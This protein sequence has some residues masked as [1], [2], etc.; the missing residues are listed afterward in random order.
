[1]RR[2]GGCNPKFGKL[3]VKRVAPQCRSPYIRRSM[4]LTETDNIP[5][6]PPGTRIDYLENGLA[7]IIR[8]DHSAPVVSAQVWCRAGSIHE[9]KWLG[10]G[11]SHILEHM[12][13]K[14]TKTRPGSRIDQEVQDIGGY[15]NAY[16]SF[17]RTVYYINA[18]S[19]GS[20]VVVDILCDIAQ[21]ATLPEEELTKELDVIRREMDMGDDDPGRK[22]GR[23]LFEV[24]YTT[25][26]YRHTI[27]GYP[28]IFDRITRP[29]VLEYYTTKYAPN[30]L[31][32]VVAGDV[33]PEEVLE[34][35]RATFADNPARPMAPE[36]LPLEPQQT[37]PREV[38][39]ETAVELG[40]LHY[41]W[42]IPDVRHADV[43]ALD[44]LAVI[45]GSGYSS[46]L[47]Q[48]VREKAGLVHSVDAWTYNP[49]LPGL[50]GMSAMFEAGQL[51]AVKAAMLA[52]LERIRSTE[53]NEAELRKAVKQFVAATLGTR[54]TMSG[55]AQDL[56]ANWLAAY[57]LNF[58]ERYLAAVKR[59]TPSD[60]QRVAKSHLT[61]ENRTLYALLPE[62]SRPP[63]E[64]S[65]EQKIDRPVEKFEL[66]NGLRVLIKEDHR[67][68]FVNFRLAFQG[69]VL[70]E[71][72]ETNGL[73]QLVA[74]SSIKGT[75][76]RSAQQIAVEME[77]L[78]GHIDCYAGN[79]SFGV[80]AEVLSGDFDMGLDI[81]ADVALNPAFS[82]DAI[83]REREVQLASIR[84]RR[85]DLLPSAGLLMRRTLFGGENYGRDQLGTEESVN[86]LTSELAIQ[87]HQK[88]AVPNNG[89]LAVFGDVKAADVRNAVEKHF[90]S[91][92]RN[93]SVK[94]GAL[95][96][97]G[98]NTA[99]AQ[100]VSE[101][102]DK[103]QAVLVV[104][105]PG[106]SLFDDDRATLDL[107]QESCSDLGSRLFMRI[108]DDLG[109]AYYVGAQNF[110]GLIPGY[111]SFYVGTSPES[112]GQCEEEIMK[113]VEALR[114]DGLSEEELNRSKAKVIGHKKIHRQDL[115]NLAMNSVLDE[116][117]G[118]G[119]NHHEEEDRQYLAVTHEDTIRVA[120]KI[121]DPAKAIVAL[122]K[123]A[124]NS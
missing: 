105:F 20:R 107:I 98:F 75:R 117:Y 6:M 4:S 81:L 55:Q 74:K 96:A 92:T 35:I 10:A 45:L 18:P 109:L 91:W 19:D 27:I 15:M 89:V 90:S 84:A 59:L 101:I 5:V 103:K 48:E 3:L 118:L 16:T 123:P 124:E 13:F 33:N 21:N 87:H 121:L 83:Q 106:L 23:R 119:F 95:E 1:M 50:F 22:S 17:D 38:I 120:Q 61:P 49:G 104:G 122:I 77:T 57:D 76:S 62:G 70:S 12:L 110:V 25:S 56:G 63:L 67:L 31:F 88:L 53:V 37:A 79:N 99:D 40:H 52:E 82:E 108:R 80:S 43:P 73:S 102:R 7:I 58:S 86:S 113:E 46:R 9:G 54:K 28:D 32:Y 11:L 111:F 68:P 26:P 85:D 94:P 2:F 97:A 100:H 30:N 93:D 14:G 41:S 64:L 8:E 114:T 72:S 34:Q 115:G 116:L 71:N 39:E 29:D 51:D 44:V 69:G 36:Y 47:Y 60:L 112:A 42:H 65:T 78:G 24:A 66:P